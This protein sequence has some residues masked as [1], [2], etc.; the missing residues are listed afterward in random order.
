[1]ALGQVFSKYFSFPCQSFYRLLYTHHHPSFGAGTTGQIVG[2]V[3]SALIPPP[4]ETM[5]EERTWKWV[6][7]FLP[8][9][10]YT[11]QT[12]RRH[13][14]ARRWMNHTVGMKAEKEEISTTVRS[15]THIPRD[16]NPLRH[17]YSYL[18]DNNISNNSV[19]GSVVDTRRKVA[20]SRP[21]ED[22]E[23]FKFTYSFLPH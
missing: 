13:P 11:R 3:T 16:P 20:G 5:K 19:R 9:H 12:S 2:D 14:I 8:R 21:S 23:F 18:P 4:P 6:V 10:L 17:D 7:I 1:L 22:N 15:R